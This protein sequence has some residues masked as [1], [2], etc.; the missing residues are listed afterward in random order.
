LRPSGDGASMPFS[1][2]GRADSRHA[3]C[4]TNPRSID[5][6]GVREGRST[7]GPRVARSTFDGYEWRAMGVPRPRAARHP[8]V[9]VVATLP[10]EHAAVA[11][12]GKRAS[13][14]DTE[15]SGKH[16]AWAATRAEST[17]SA[18]APSHGRLPG[19]AALICRTRM[20]GGPPGDRRPGEASARGP[21]GLTNEASTRGPF[22]RPTGADAHERTAGADA[23]V[24]R[25]HRLRADARLCRARTT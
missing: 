15:T 23:A 8:P 1:M 7:S 3:R 6:T 21:P 5:L 19:S 11:D 14:I 22:E 9:P 25:D 18:T 17:G 13:A 10:A 20:A 2:Q 16:T 12:S 4:V 24:R